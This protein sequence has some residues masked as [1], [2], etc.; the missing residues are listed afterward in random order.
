MLIRKAR[1]PKEILLPTKRRRSKE[2]LRK[3]HKYL[4]LMNYLNTLSLAAMYTPIA[5]LRTNFDRKTLV[6]IGRWHFTS[7]KQ[8]NNL[9]ADDLSS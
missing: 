1:Q 3:A 2:T 7:I 8:W 5:A 9:V 4:L 6:A